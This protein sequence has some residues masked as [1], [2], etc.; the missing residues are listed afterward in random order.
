VAND[1]YITLILNES[2]VYALGYKS[3]E[4]AIDQI[5]YLKLW[6]DDFERY[7]IV[8]IVED[9]HHESA[10]REVLPTILTF[11]KR[12]QMV[13]YSIKL[14]S[15]S[16]PKE[17]LAYIEKNWK[18]IFPDKPFDYFF[19]D[20]YYDR[21]FKSEVAF[22]RIFSLFSGIA[23]FIAFVGILGM[24]LFEAN[25]RIKEISIR[26]VLGATITNLM[27]LLSKKYFSLIVVAASVASPLI[28]FS[29]K[30]WLE[31]YPVRIEIGVSTFVVPF[32]AL[33]LVI[34]FASG[35]QT[36]KAASTNPVDHLKNE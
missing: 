8:G 16:N 29:S 4:E 12:F 9:Y 14:Q 34:A 22:T 24:T 18:E 19:L 5:I 27:L 33:V 36:F 23:M 11:F 1:Y 20:E 7:K 3:V 30:S 15:G 31:T 32:I 13:Y 6:G 2:A 28:Y 21:Q 35:F 25:L 10:K 17:A 26:K